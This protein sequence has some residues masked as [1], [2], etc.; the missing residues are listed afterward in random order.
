VAQQNASQANPGLMELAE[1]ERKMR[2]GL[3]RYPKMEQYIPTMME[4]VNNYPMFR[5][6][7]FLIPQQAILETSGGANITRPNNLI[8]W[9]IR[10]PEANA[11]FSQMTIEDVLKAAMD[12]LG[13]TTS[14]PAY[15]ALHH[16]RKATP[17][18]L[19]MYANTYEPANLSYYD[20]L[21][22]GIEYFEG[23]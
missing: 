2:A 3:N 12:R 17:E 16:G 7:P 18:E 15:K 22:K 23:L 20:N 8:N 14:I 1:I 6:N 19:K 10:D 21:A 4:A 13:K 5:A 11:R 9:G